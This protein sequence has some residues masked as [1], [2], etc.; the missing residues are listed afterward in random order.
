MCVLI[1]QINVVILVVAI[2]IVSVKIGFVNHVVEDRV[3]AVSINQ[4]KIKR[5][6]NNLLERS[7]NR[8][9]MVQSSSL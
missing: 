2:N 6:R 3:I 5:C 9:I 8:W 1:L 4:I 7:V